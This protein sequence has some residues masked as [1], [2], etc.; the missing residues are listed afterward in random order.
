MSHYLPPK[1]LTKS[2]VGEW[3]KIRTVNACGIK[4]HSIISDSIVKAE[5][6]NSLERY[7]FADFSLSSDSLCSYLTCEILLKRGSVQDPTR[8][9]EVDVS[10]MGLENIETDLHNKFSSLRK[11]TA[12]DNA[13]SFDIFKHFSIL[14]QLDLSLNQMSRLL[15]YSGGFKYLQN[16]NLSYN[17]L[18][19]SDV[20]QLG[21][22][23]SL[24]ILFLC[25]NDLRR[26]PPDF[27]ESGITEEGDII[28]KFEKLE[29]LHLD[30]NKLSDAQDFA[31][32]ATLPRLKFLN[33]SNNKFNTVPLLKSTS[34]R[35]RQTVDTM[36][37]SVTNDLSIDVNENS[38][39]E[40]QPISC[41]SKC[42]NNEILVISGKNIKT[43][44]SNKSDIVNSP[45]VHTKTDLNSAN[46]EDIVVNNGK[47]ASSNPPF[48]AQRKHSKKKHAQDYS[49]LLD[50]H[51]NPSAPRIRIVD[52]FIGLS[53]LNKVFPSNQNKRIKYKQSIDKSNYSK[54][55]TPS[56]SDQRV[57]F[58]GIHKTNSKNNRKCKE[59]S[60]VLSNTEQT[61]DNSLSS[62]KQN[63]IV[64]SNRMPQQPPPFQS[65]Q[66]ID[67][68]HNKISCEEHLLP[69][70]VW[71]KLKEIIIYDNPVIKKTSKLPPLLERLL[72]KQLNINLRR[73]PIDDPSLFRFNDVGFNGD[74]ELAAQL[75]LTHNQNVTNTEIVTATS[76]SSSKS[77]SV[78]NNSRN[79]GILQKNRRRLPLQ[80]SIKPVIVRHK[81]D[82]SSLNEGPKVIKFNVDK[83]LNE[84]KTANQ[85]AA[86]SQ[87]N[88]L[89]NRSSYSS[90]LSSP[91]SSSRHTTATI[92]TTDKALLP[93]IPHKIPQSLQLPPIK[94][95]TLSVKS[96]FQ[97]KINLSEISLDLQ[98]EEADEE[99]FNT[100]FTTQL[101]SLEANTKQASRHSSYRSDYDDELNPVYQ[102]NCEDSLLSVNET[103]IVQVTEKDSGQEQQQKLIEYSL[104]PGPLLPDLEWLVDEDNL[105]DSMQACL[106]EL[107]YLLQ[108]KPT[109][110]LTSDR[111]VN[112]QSSLLMLPENEQTVQL[113]TELISSPAAV[114]K[115]INKPENFS[116]T[117]SSASIISSIQ[118]SP[119][120]VELVPVSK[121]SEIL[122][123]KI[124]FN[125]LTKKYTNFIEIPLP[126]ALDNEELQRQQLEE[127]RA[128]QN[129]LAKTRK[130]NQLKLG[131]CH[132]KRTENKEAKELFEQVS[133]Y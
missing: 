24:R 82:R 20:E 4:S 98:S 21:Y 83:A 16:L 110:H 32:L 11:I 31:S 76:N 78:E 133:Q 52:E 104:S 108:H 86:I 105:P 79:K 2:Q 125:Q 13:F 46:T 45:H 107:R 103:A 51:R 124:D 93:D 71:P 88:P 128:K 49:L 39:M 23:P 106:R 121:T 65:L 1:S 3:T 81:L 27:A 102:Q 50:E 54:S 59:N 60:R 101:S 42:Q 111:S 116:E 129:P 9:F 28:Y 77:I 14:S 47:Y 92:T 100:F 119:A 87:P 69:V 74:C 113:S 5:S 18:Q 63:S 38:K 34:Q 55:N 132:S 64:I 17:F 58:T 48:P 57:G 114:E 126:K 33:L 97:E 40:N 70:A 67:L 127:I 90:N 25:G 89:S 109:V 117:N 19:P 56:Q 22:L 43:T 120:S 29:V 91:S 53:N 6:Q 115:E 80:S 85:K 94:N 15:P 118:L 123:S 72:I 35:K 84:L 96:N 41:N 122:P 30:D 99:N 10:A 8:L 44:S 130:W 131:N 26:L 73:N 37:D 75:S 95:T 12:T 62:A 36:K 7:S 112:R 61:T 66:F 68:S